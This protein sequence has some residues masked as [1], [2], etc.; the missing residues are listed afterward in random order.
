MNNN[1]KKTRK[2]HDPKKYLLRNDAQNYAGEFKNIRW[3][4]KAAGVHRN[5]AS[6]VID[7]ICLA[8]EGLIKAAYTYE[9]RRSKFPEYIYQ[10]VKEAL[11][12]D[13]AEKVATYTSELR[14]VLKKTSEKQMDIY[15]LV[16]GLDGA[17]P[18]SIKAAAA[19]MN[20]REQNVHY[21][22]GRLYKNIAEVL[23]ASTWD[24]STPQT[25]GDSESRKT[26]T[27]SPE[28]ARGKLAEFTADGNAKLDGPGIM[29]VIKLAEEGDFFVIPQE[30]VSAFTINQ[31]QE[32]KVTVEDGGGLL[33]TAEGKESGILCKDGKWFIP[34]EDM[35]QTKIFITAG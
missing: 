25:S 16:F 12:S 5:P 29:L 32:L 24:D 35:N 30:M 4:L 19:E 13:E 23:S 28:E 11:S 20:L 1:E 31:N 26:T 21:A 18:V 9:G 15:R 34:K 7:V 6:D 27:P 10:C 17:V 3:A 22:V 33:V 2:A 14:R 8:L